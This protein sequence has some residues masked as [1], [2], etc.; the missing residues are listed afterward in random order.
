VSIEMKAPPC[1]PSCTFDWRQFHGLLDRAIVH[2]LEDNLDSRS[3][4][5]LPS[6]TSL[7]D[8]MNYSHAKVQGALGD[9]HNS[10]ETPQPTS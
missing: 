6:H 1:P 8:F 7:L 4:D 9:E 10:T 3:L 5:A 2:Y